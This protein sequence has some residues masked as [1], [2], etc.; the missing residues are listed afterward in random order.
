MIII[1]VG[2]CRSSWF[3]RSTTHITTL[4]KSPLI[5]NSCLRRGYGI[6]VGDN[7]WRNILIQIGQ[8]TLDIQIK[9]GHTSRLL[10][11]SYLIDTTLEKSLSGAKLF[12]TM[13]IST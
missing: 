4:S 1:I 10:K 7:N 11:D 13:I 5:S 2:S 9:S 8:I 3:N 6:L 12:F